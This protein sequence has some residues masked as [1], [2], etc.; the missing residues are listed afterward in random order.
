MPR[1]LRSGV[2]GLCVALV[3]GVLP[4]AAQVSKGE[5]FGKVTD[6][7]GAVLPGVAVTIESPALI[8]PQTAVTEASGGYRSPNIPIG[9]YSVR[10]ELNGFKKLVRTDVV[11]TAGFNAEINAKLELSTVQETVTVSGE[12]PVV[13]T[14]S[15]QVGGTFNLKQMQEIPTARDP[16]EIIQQTPGMSM[17]SENVGG[18]GSGQQPGFNVHGTNTNMWTMDGAPLTHTS[19]KSAPVYYDCDSFA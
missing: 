7:T 13:D 8:Q 11:I 15:T 3:A 14:R 16:W 12:S 6:T 1:V 18:N 19:S 4:A 10:F 5:I 17:T 2:L 9:T